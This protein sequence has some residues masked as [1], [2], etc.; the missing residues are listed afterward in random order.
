[1]KSAKFVLRCKACWDLSSKNKVWPGN[2][3]AVDAGN[4]AVLSEV[5]WFSKLEQH[6]GAY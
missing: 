2:T 5:L 1:M 4:S 6:S 3:G